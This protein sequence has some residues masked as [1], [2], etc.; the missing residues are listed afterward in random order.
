MARSRGK[1]TAGERDTNAD[2]GTSGKFFKR[3]QEE[4]EHDVRQEGKGAKKQ[5]VDHDSSSRKSSSYKL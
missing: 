3:M 1:I 5:K 4:V 2:Y